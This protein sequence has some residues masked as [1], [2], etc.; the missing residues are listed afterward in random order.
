[1]MVTPMRASLSMF[2]RCIT[3]SGISRTTRMSWRRSFITT[4]AARSRRSSLLPCAIADKVPLVQ[5]HTPIARGALE[6]L[7]ADHFELAGLRAITRGQRLLYLRGT[8][9]EL[10][11]GLHADH[12]LRRR[13]QHEID[14][15]P[16]AEQALQQPQAVNGAR[17]AGHGESDGIAAHAVFMASASLSCSPPK[18]PL[19]MISTWSPGRTTAQMA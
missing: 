19:L 9:R 13:R 11:F 8:A 3:E 4:S 15:L 14:L 6:P 5:G 17:R 12:H 18:A 1:M 16:G 2:S 10:Q 7:A